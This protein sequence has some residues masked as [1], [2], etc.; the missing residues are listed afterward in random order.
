M[1]PERTKLTE[2]DAATAYARAWNRL[3]PAQFLELLAPDARYASQW[4]L[5]E[6]DNRSAITEYLTGK[7]RAVRM[8]AINDP[9]WKVFAE[10]GK[11]TTGF[12]GR[13]CVF[14]SQGSKENVT[15]A[16]LFKVENGMVKRF[17]LC[18]PQL[19]GVVRSGVY[20]I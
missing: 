17:D 3:D 13:D 15:A 1:R 2:A 5:D 4:V 9:Y 19:L 11:T 6:L 12:S 14:L 8:Y 18:I 20:P 7:M 10:L 16:V